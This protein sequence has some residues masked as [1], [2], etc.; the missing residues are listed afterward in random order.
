MNQ[1]INRPLEQNT[2]QFQVPS[3]PS[4]C[5]HY[6]Q[7]SNADQTSIKTELSRIKVER[8]HSPITRND[9][10][11]QSSHS[12]NQCTTPPLPQHI[13]DFHSMPMETIPR[14]Y[15]MS[16]EQSFQ[17]PEYQH[18]LRYLN[19]MASHPGS[20]FIMDDPPNRMGYEMSARPY[21]LMAST[22][23]SYSSYLP[24]TISTTESLLQL[25]QPMFIQ[26][27]HQSEPHQMAP[28]KSIDTADYSGPV[29]PRAMYQPYETPGFSVMNLTLK[30]ANHAQQL[31]TE[32]A[33]VNSPPSSDPIIDLSAATARSTQDEDP[34]KTPILA[35]PLEAS[36]QT[37][38][39]R[40]GR[41]ASTRR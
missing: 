19:E 29:Y 15:N 10:S 18:Q 26:S 20:T 31:G 34:Q 36:P 7:Q 41:M 25:Q 14:H 3:Q 2:S 21:D 23:N 5:I 37:L 6:Q 28:I 4:P 16:Y 8:P 30:M 27:D 22:T 33:V 38:D 39:L 1:N 11:H 9:Q 12:R 35:S 40:V 32:T 17:Q 13:N 24:T